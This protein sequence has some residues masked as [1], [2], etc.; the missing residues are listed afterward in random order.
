MR[1]TNTSKTERRHVGLYFFV[2]NSTAA[3]Y[4]RRMTH[5]AVVLKV[6]FGLP[7][8][9]ANFCLLPKKATKNFKL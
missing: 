6:F 2:E 4:Q 3:E 7:S 5:G 9:Y 8:F 1:I